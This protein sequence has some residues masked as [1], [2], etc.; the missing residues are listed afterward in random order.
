MEEILK[1]NKIPTTITN[2][3]ITVFNNII[4]TR[5]FKDLDEEIKHTIINQTIGVAVS[6]SKMGGY[7]YCLDYLENNEL[8]NT[9]Q[10]I[11]NPLFSMPGKEKE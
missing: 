8:C 3:I 9:I 11:E 7:S 5:L 1:S 6:L 4:K 2:E 10:R